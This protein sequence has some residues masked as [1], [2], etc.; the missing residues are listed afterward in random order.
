MLFKLVKMISLACKN[1]TS[2][3]K[4]AVRTSKKWYLGL[5]K[6]IPQLVKMLFEPVKKYLGL[7]KILL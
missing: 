2:T 4:D 7:V 6:I 5:V 3:C 1:N